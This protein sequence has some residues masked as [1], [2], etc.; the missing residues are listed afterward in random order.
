[1]L[2][3]AS[4]RTSEGRGVHFFERHTP[5]AV[6]RFT[7]RAVAGTNAGFAMLQTLEHRQAESFHQRRIYRERATPVGRLKFGVAGGPVIDQRSTRA[8]DRSD[9]LQRGGG[10]IRTRQA[11]QLQFE[12]EA[13]G[14]KRFARLEQ[15]E[16]I[17]A[18][19][20]RADAQ[21]ARYG[22][23]GHVTYYVTC[24]QAQRDGYY[25]GTRRH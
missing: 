4:D 22:V 17:L 24:I 6:R 5:A 20:D 8:L 7:E 2:E 13:L 9:F 19:L 12:C 18:T 15:R 21:H 3:Q 11:K 25:G 23:A 16:V 1:M 14:P 10:G